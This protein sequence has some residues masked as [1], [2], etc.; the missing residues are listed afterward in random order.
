MLASES[1]QKFVR[2]TNE[3]HTESQFR[4]LSTNK[5]PECIS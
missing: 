5:L 3:D 1:H 4:E 2:Q